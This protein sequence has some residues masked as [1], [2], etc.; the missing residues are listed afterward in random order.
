MKTKKGFAFTLLTV[1]SI[2]AALTIALLSYVGKTARLRVASQYTAPDY[3]R[4][5]SQGYA[6]DTVSNKKTVLLTV[7]DGELPVRIHICTIDIDKNMLDILELPPDTFIVVDGFSGTLREAFS[8]PVYKEMISRVLCLRINGSVSFDAK[9]LGDASEMLGVIDSASGEN[10][11]LDGLTYSL[12]DSRSVI[13]YRQLLA[14]DL[15]KLSSLGAL[16]SF[17]LLMNLIV[18]RVSTDM[19]IEEMIDIVSYTDDIRAKKMNIHIAVGGPARLG[20]NR[21]WVLNADAMSELLNE[22]F[23]VKGIEYSAESLSIPS[24]TAGEFPY[25]N[26]PERVTDIIS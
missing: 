22:H 10:I 17:T 15:I 9:T 14:S 26:L 5:I 3:V 19:S 8:T 6:L 25:K 23:R 2:T 24:L 18:N 21:V 7:T 12:G 16:D 20:E 1:C 11:A 4:Y 13:A